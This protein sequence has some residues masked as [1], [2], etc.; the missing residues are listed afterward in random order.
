[1]DTRSARGHVRQ[2]PRLLLPL[3]LIGLASCA[4]GNQW[5]W[6]PATAIGE[7]ATRDMALWGRPETEADMALACGDGELRIVVTGLAEDELENPRPDPVTLRAGRAA[8]RGAAV[9]DPD[10]LYGA[11]VIAIP[12]GHPLVD[13]IA[14]GAPRLWFDW[15]DRRRATLRLGRIPARFVG[16]CRSLEAGG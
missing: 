14:R 5:A 9:I 12:L 6:K 4:T 15:A 2:V 11:S 13:A 7:S 16:H 8:F 1:M 10:D 3:L